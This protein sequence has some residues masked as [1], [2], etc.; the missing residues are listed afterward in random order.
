MVEDVIV[1][2]PFP[3]VVRTANLTV[4]FGTVL[5]DEAKKI[6]RW[7]VGKITTNRKCTLTGR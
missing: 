3:R 4:N 2:I 6:A 5:F 7:N 1:I